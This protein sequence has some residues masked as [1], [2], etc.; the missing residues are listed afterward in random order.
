VNE[1]YEKWDTL[2]PRGLA[3][4]GLG[5]SITGQAIGAKA[6]G[7]GFFRW[8]I[9]GT[10]GLIIVNSGVALF[11]EAVKNRALYEMKINKTFEQNL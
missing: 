3:L 10:L 1:H 6:N 2:A 9:L 8:F 7:K 11:G 5:L 4:I